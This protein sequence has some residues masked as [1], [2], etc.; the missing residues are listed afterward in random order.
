MKKSRIDVE[1]DVNMVEEDIRGK[2]DLPYHWYGDC[3]GSL[4]EDRFGHDL[5]TDMELA[6]TEEEYQEYL[7]E[8]KEN[9][10]KQLLLGNK[11]TK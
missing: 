11:I 5:M 1:Y 7:N 9:F 6:T 10:E 2:Y 3:Y 8:I 4:I